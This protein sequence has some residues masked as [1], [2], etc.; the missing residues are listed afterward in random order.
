MVGEPGADGPPGIPGAPGPPGV[1][2]GP[3]DYS[4]NVEVSI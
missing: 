1:P 2:G 4:N 3:I